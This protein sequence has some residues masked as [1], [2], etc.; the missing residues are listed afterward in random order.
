VAAQRCHPTHARPACLH[1][2]LR[3]PP[4]G[5]RGAAA[6]TAGERGPLPR[7]RP[8]HGPLAR[9]LRGLLNQDFTDALSVT[10]EVFKRIVQGLYTPWSP[11]RFDV[12]GVEILGSIYERALGSVIILDDDRRVSIELK[13]EV[14]KAGGVYYTPQWV[15]E[16]I[17]RLTIDPLIAG[18]RPRDLQRFRVLDLACGSGSFLLGA[19]ARDAEVTVRRLAAGKHMGTEVLEG[20]RNGTAPFEAFTRRTTLNSRPWRFPNPHTAALYE[21]LDASGEHL[22]TLCEL[23][24][25]MQTG[26]NGVFGKLCDEDVASNGLPPSL[27]KQR[28]RN[29]DIHASHILGS[30]EWVLYLEDVTRY[31][32]LPKSVQ[33]YLELPANKAK[34][35]DRAAFEH[36]NC[37]WWKYTWPLHKDLHHQ[38]QII[39]PY[40]TSHNRSSRRR[41]QLATGCRSDRSLAARHIEGR[42]KQLDEVRWI[43]GITGAEERA[44]ILAL[45]HHLNDP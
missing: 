45:E 13:P 31:H 30:G 25:G 40:R 2:R 33:A 17:V 43:Y 8:G 36:G 44:S 20:L 5:A 10:P 32:D 16:E 22:S 26:A 38:P 41:S 6:P 1:P 21:R 7:V 34:P 37:E 39:C 29:S 28:A 35:K 3:G 14:R 19:F 27:L 9:E 42:I 15:V 11:Y 23:G 24:Q 18:K 12:L 4:A